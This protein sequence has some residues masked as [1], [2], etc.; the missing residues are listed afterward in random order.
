MILSG[1]EQLIVSSKGWL[2]RV[3][4]WMLDTGTLEHR[5]IPLAEYE[6]CDTNYLEVIAGDRERFLVRAQHAHGYTVSVRRFDSPDTALASVSVHGGEVALGGNVDEWAD[7]RRVFVGSDPIGTLYWLLSIDPSGS[8]RVE[9]LE[10]FNSGGYDLLY[11]SVLTPVECPQ[12][13]DL[14]VVPVQRS[15]RLVV[16]NRRTRV[17]VQRVS[18][19]E[20]Y[21]NPTARF[22]RGELWCDDYDTLLRLSVE[23][24]SVKDSLLL[25]DGTVGIARRHIGDWTFTP[26]GSL[27]V[28]ARPFSGDVVALD[29]ESFRMI[30]HVEL[31]REPLGVA[32]LSDGR[33]IARD[34]LTGDLLVGRLSV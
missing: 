9:P 19:A 3:A 29:T 15:S 27:C 31:G 17:V 5:L 14:V 10:W 26:G 25:Q 21:G 6:L 1:D 12:D 32:A 34:R 7:L 28:V 18:L 2:D 33:V 23:D 11:Q 16:Y 8:A 22:F 30:H 20:R 24:W 4:L 13:H